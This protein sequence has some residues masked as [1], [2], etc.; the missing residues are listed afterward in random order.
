MSTTPITAEEFNSITIRRRGPSTATSPLGCGLRDVQ[1]GEGF[2]IP[3]TYSHK[4]HIKNSISCSG[5]SS[6]HQTAN[7]HGFKV[8]CK[9]YEGI[10]YVLRQHEE[11]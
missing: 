4:G 2:K 8:N 3:C 6:A 7:R 11:A 5:I 9:C 1:P 10:L